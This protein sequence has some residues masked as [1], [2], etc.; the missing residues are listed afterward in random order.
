MPPFNYSLFLFSQAMKQKH[1]LVK[2][3]EPPGKITTFL[4][5]ISVTQPP[6]VADDDDYSVDTSGSSSPMD[7]V[8]VYLFVY[9]SVIHINHTCTKSS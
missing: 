8:Q 4:P 6:P 9:F 7:V 2:P 1:T 3:V 5:P